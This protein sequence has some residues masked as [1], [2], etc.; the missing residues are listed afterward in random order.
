MNWLVWLIEH[1][2]WVLAG[3]ILLL[4]LALL[5]RRRHP[6]ASRLEVDARDPFRRWCQAAMMLIT[7]DC[8]Y[9]HLQRG[10]ARRMLQRWWH[11]HGARDLHQT[12]AELSSSPNPDNAWELLRFMIVARLGAAAEMLDD[13]ES[14]Q[15]LCAPANRLQAAYEGWTAMAQAYVTA[16]RQ[17]QDLPLD[18]SA[19]DD[20]M[21]WIT[22]NFQSLRAGAWTEVDWDLELEDE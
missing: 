2:P 6:A 18:G 17:W 12:L 22:E 19:D 8:D 5:L 7:R 1:W 15:M 14:W 13:D 4:T 10:E 16:R 11:V 20:T 21:R 9:G 3:V